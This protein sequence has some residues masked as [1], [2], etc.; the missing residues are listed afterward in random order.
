M[1][2][3]VVNFMTP[4]EYFFG[5]EGW[6]GANEQGGVYNRAF[7]GLRIKHASDAVLE[8]LDS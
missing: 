2:A 4:E 6:D 3:C 5:N 8:A 7:C 1:C